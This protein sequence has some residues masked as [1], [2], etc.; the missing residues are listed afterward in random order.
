MRL[1]EEPAD[2]ESYVPV[3]W[4]PNVASICSA[5]KG[6][7]TGMVEDAMIAGAGV[8]GRGCTSSG[9]RFWAS[10]GYIGGEE[11]IEQGGRNVGLDKMQLARET[12]S[13]VV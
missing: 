11:S 1:D 4:E 9:P 10:M 7:E 3:Y 12:C 6:S 5:L 2:D 8:F 13:G